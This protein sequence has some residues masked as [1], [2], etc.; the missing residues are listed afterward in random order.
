VPEG[1]TIFQTAAALRPLLV[2]QRVSAARASRPGPAIERIVGAAVTSIEPVGKHMLIHFDNGLAL[3]THLRMNG[4]WHRYAPGE[5]WRRPAWQARVV[6][7]VP[8][9]VV[10]CFS[11][12]VVELMDA[13]AVALHPALSKLGPDLLGDSFD[14]AEA[15]NRL[16]ARADEEIGTAL[17]DQTALAGIGNVY[18]S[19]VLFIE[20]VNPFDRVAQLDEA[21]LARL[22]TTAERLL[23]DNV[24]TPDP[25]RI[26]TRE[27][28][29]VGGRD[30]DGASPVW[31]YGRAGRACFRCRTA[32]AVRRQGTRLP[33]STYW[34]PTCQ[35]RRPC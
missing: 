5:R 15:L 10:V 25:R 2:G 8:G 16:H 3:H 19:E 22:V 35:P 4:S 1:D 33:R 27:P 21:T 23:R 18:K 26:T 24:R 30:R 13:R 6:I 14:A 29:A 31:V 11:A 9:H 34:C 17:L 32:I 12:P 7:E 28:G 20:G